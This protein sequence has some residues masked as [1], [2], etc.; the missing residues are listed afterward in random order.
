MNALNISASLCDHQPAAHDD[1]PEQSAGARDVAIHYIHH[2]D[3]DDRDAVHTILEQLPEVA[4][5]DDHTSR[6]RGTDYCLPDRSVLD[7]QTESLLFLRMNFLR[8]LA[9]RRQKKLSAGTSPD[10]ERRTIRNLLNEANRA[11]DE[12]ASSH[13]RLVVSNAALFMGRGV[14]LADLIS[15]AN[16]SL[17]MAI[18]SFDVSRGFRLSTYA[19]CAMRRHLNRHVR[20]EQ[21]R[22]ARTDK[23][24]PEPIIEEDDAEWIDVHPGRLADDILAALPERERRMVRLRYGLTPDGRSRTLEEVA[25]EFNISKERVRQLVKRACTRAHDKYAQKLGLTESNPL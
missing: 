16:V 21:R 25:G 3:F 9:A 12:L 13:Q 4:R 24:L 20:R 19:T 10:L 14:S 6:I 8:C 7:R 22:T 1:R 15:E 23:V 11:R 17:L 2:P 5:R 18:D